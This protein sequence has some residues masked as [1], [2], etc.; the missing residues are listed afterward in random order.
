MFNAIRSKFYEFSARNINGQMV[1]MSQYQGYVV[2][3]VNVASKC[4]FTKKN[5]TELVELDERYR[6][7]GLRILGFP[8]NQF[9]NQEPG[10]NE[11][12]KEFVAKYNVKFDMF[13]KVE[14]NGP[15]AHPLF[16]YLQ[17]ELSGFITNAIK[18]NFTKVSD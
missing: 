16:A 11:D 4:G 8:S 14:V 2:L 5:Y 18:W 12:I 6:E 17:N 3:V 15:N 9:N 13:E 7:R 1:S 10:T